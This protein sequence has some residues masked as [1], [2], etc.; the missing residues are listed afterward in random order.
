[1]EIY[2][3]SDHAGFSYKSLLIQYIQQKGHTIHD[4]GAYSEERVNYPEYAYHVCEAVLQRDNVYGILICGSGIGMSMYANRFK[5]IR[6][7]LCTTEYQSS[8]TRK[9]NNANILCIGA[10]VTGIDIVYSMVDIF[11]TTEYEGGRHQIR[12]HELDTYKL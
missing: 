10:R 4:C 12:V 1:M 9:H 7:A 8:M 3:A 6:A 2:I 5:G 11:C